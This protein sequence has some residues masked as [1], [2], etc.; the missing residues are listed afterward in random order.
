MTEPTPSERPP[1]EQLPDE[2][3]PAFLAFSAFRDLG[4]ARTVVEAYRQSRGKP[5][6]KQAPGT[7]NGWAKRFDWAARAHA[8][9]AHLEAARTAG[10]AAGTEKAAADQAEVWEQRR[11]QLHEEVFGL[12]WDLLRESRAIVRRYQAAAGQPGGPALDSGELRR[13]A[14]VG[15]EAEA[16]ARGAINSSLPAEDL[17]P[18]RSIWELSQTPEIQAEAAKRLEEWKEEKRRQGEEWAAARA[19]E[20]ASDNPVC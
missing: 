20:L 10:A 14:L 15:R 19:A 18:G 1:W 7:W 16:L 9:D 8:F 3:G 2:P 4:P 6:A 13:A 12:A 11:G 17:S 5:E